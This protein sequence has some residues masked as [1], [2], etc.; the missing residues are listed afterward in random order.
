MKRPRSRSHLDVAIRKIAGNEREFVRLRTTLANTIVGQMLPNGVVKGGTALKLRYGI[1][2]TR[3]TTDLDTARSDSV[4]AF[5]EELGARLAEGWEGFTGRIVPRRP[6][7]PT[8]IPTQYVMQ[9]S[10]IK[11]SYLGRSWCTVRLEVGHNEVGD[12]DEPEWCISRDI[13]EMF[14]RVGFP[15]PSPVPLMPLHHQI[16]QKL[17]GLSEPGSGRAHDLVDLQLIMKDA[18]IDMAKVRAK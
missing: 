15:E 8:G 11:M 6:A 17:H 16:A 12:A 5:I 2:K 7:N 1:A 4:D 10:D 14:L 9:P 13:V 18:G 3:F